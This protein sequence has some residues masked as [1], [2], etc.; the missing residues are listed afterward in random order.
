M[1]DSQELS[2]SEIYALVWAYEVGL[3]DDRVDDVQPDAPARII[4]IVTILARLCALADI[5]P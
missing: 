1:M 5:E 4:D 2:V 3:L